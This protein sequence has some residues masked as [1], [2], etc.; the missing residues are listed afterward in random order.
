MQAEDWVQSGRVEAVVGDNNNRL[1]GF[2]AAAWVVAVADSWWVGLVVVV[3][4][5]SNPA[6]VADAADW[7][8]G[9]NIAAELVAARAAGWPVADSI[10]AG[11]EVEH[12]VADWLAAVDIAVQV[13]AAAVAVNQSP[14][15]R[16]AD[17]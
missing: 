2:V 12:V 11:V 6:V 16:H 7:D 3:E 8:W 10:A 5:S 13:A 1:A 17:G 4:D 9:Y 14:E 15:V